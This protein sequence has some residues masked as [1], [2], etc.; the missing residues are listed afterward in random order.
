MTIVARIM[1]VKATWNATEEHRMQNVD[2][3]TRWGR[4]WSGR[5]STC[6]YIIIIIHVTRCID[7]STTITVGGGCS[8]DGSIATTNSIRVIMYMYC[9]H[10]YVRSSVYFILCI[11]WICIICL[12]ECFE[13]LVFHS[14]ILYHQR[15][16]S[17]LLSEA[18]FQEK[19]YRVLTFSINARQQYNTSYDIGKQFS[20]SFYLS[21][22][23]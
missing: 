15:C 8:M 6:M 2:K 22:I 10:Q 7:C 13:L 9:R 3:Q 16:L 11:Y 1:I 5:R 14:N 21:N 4:G 19:V 18:V 20:I 17:S 12:N 23:V